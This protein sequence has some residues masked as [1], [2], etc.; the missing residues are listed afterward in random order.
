MLCRLYK[1]FFSLN[2]LDEMLACADLLGLF[3]CF[4]NLMKISIRVKK[5]N[6][7]TIYKRNFSG[8]IKNQKYQKYVTQKFVFASKPS[9][10]KLVKLLLEKCSSKDHP[11][12]PLVQFSC[13]ELGGVPD[14]LLS[15]LLDQVAFK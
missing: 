3:G 1:I 2:C 12:Q 8:N 4:F 5:N 6:N 10:H 9:L 14:A 13:T 11:E 7:S 15:Q